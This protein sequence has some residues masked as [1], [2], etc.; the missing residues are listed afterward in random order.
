MDVAL[1]CLNTRVKNVRDL[2]MQRNEPGFRL[3]ERFPFHLRINVKTTGTRTKTIR[4]LVERA[5]HVWSAKDGQE[6]TVAVSV[7]V[8][9]NSLLPMCC[10]AGIFLLPIWLENP[11][12]T[13][14]VFIK[15]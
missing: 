15:P 12:A 9:H 5:G 1:A 10:V 4:G 3:W 7:Y 13:L 6:L 14:S 8:I 11:I 2:N